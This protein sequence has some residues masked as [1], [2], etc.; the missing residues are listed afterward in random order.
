M[1]P[2]PEPIAT[3]KA[4]P[5]VVIVGGGFGGLAA[6]RALA[7]Q[8]VPGSRWSTAATIT[9]SS[10]C[11]TRWRPPASRP[12]TSRMPIRA[13]LRRAGATPTCCSP[14][15][16]S[17]STS[18]GRRV[19]LDDGRARLRLPRR[20]DR[21]RPLL[22]RPRRV[23]GARP[24]PEDA[25][26]RARDPAPHPARLRGG[27]ARSDDAE[28][29]A[30]LTF[31]VVGGGPD[32]RR[33]RGRDRRDRAPRH[34]ARLPRHRPDARRGSSWSRPGARVLA[35]FPEPLS[36]SAAQ[37]LRRLGVEVRTGARVTPDRRRTRSR[38]GER[39]DR[40]RD[41]A[42]G[43]GRGG[44]AARRARSACRSTAPAASWSSPTCR[45]PGIPRSS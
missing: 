10:R 24:R 35:A 16:Q 17:R 19:I 5:H 4:T 44:V 20:R 36:R 21:R 13:V 8:P 6:A 31:V 15:S 39:A 18:S 43:G 23:G 27:R 32:R 37:A 9:S 12:P 2:P 26:G 1:G 28:R 29:R 33:A 22:L 3:P 14:R 30:L 45:S 25:R 38:L 7:R 11:S 41:R 42:L 34:R 40:A